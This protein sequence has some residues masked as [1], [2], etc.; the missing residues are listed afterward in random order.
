MYNGQKVIDI[1]GH[2][3]TPPLFRAHAMNIISLRTPGAGEGA[4][5]PDEQL[6]GPLKRHLGVMDE[7]NIDLQLLSPRPVAMLHW[8]SPRIVDYWTK[9]TNDVIH[10][11]CKMYPDRW[12]GVAQLPQNAKIPTH[13]CVDELER[14]VRQY[15]FIGAIL[16]PDPSGERDAPGVH[17]EYWYPLYEKAQELNTPL[18]VH[19]SISRDPRFDIVPHNY[20][21]NNVTEEWVAQNLYIHSDIFKTFPRLRIVI[22]HCG[23]ALNRFLNNDATHSI[24]TRDLSQNL[25]F[26]TCV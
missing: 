19:P 24:G 9:Y 6:E 8:E 22:C 15:G 20:Q 5:I 2:M 11:S 18:I 14:T 3:T 23:G 26:D 1:H 21:M 7:R 25:F 4:T 12:I 17:T 13:N 16:N 10:R